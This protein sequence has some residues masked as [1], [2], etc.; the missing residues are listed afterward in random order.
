MKKNL[1][2]R[3]LIIGVV[4]AILIIL[5]AAI[6]YY[7][8]NI[9]GRSMSDMSTPSFIG[10]TF[11]CANGAEGNV[12]AKNCR[13]EAYWN[14]YATKFC[15]DLCELS[16]DAS[17]DNAVNVDPSCQLAT[18][19][20]IGRCS[21]SPPS[22][23]ACFLG[24]TGKQCGD[25]G[26]GESC[27]TCSGSDV[28][29]DNVCKT[30]QCQPNCTGKTCGDDGCG[31]SCGICSEVITSCY[32]ETANAASPLDTAGCGLDYSGSYNIMEEY[33]PVSRLGILYINYTKPAGA[34]GASWKVK[35]G[36]FP[37]YL[38]SIPLDCFTNNIQLRMISKFIGNSTAVGYG[39]YG[40]CFDGSQW[41][42]ITNW[43]EINTDATASMVLGN[44]SSMYD[45]DWSTGVVHASGGGEWYDAAAQD[46]NP[47]N[48]ARY[49][50]VYEEAIIWDKIVSQT[51]SESGTCIPA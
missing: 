2:K 31:G 34:T 38:V 44:P 15:K 5:A 48:A 4:I 26:C 30:P 33:I 46:A 50:R 19:N 41:I 51:C 47:T 9:T 37:E 43:S 20:V 27:G 25:D 18:F 24:C 8:A 42:T 10:T 12:Q 3:N 22:P 21:G 36:L 39:S 29:I 28:C 23:G 17:I 49:G 7:N 35:H 13:P 1:S 11:K 16:L 6:Y 45:G 32:Q 40:Q 14:N